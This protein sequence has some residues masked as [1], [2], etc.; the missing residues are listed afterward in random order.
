M[1]DQ[2]PFPEPLSGRYPV[3][4]KLGEGGMGVVYLAHDNNMNCEVVVKM[5]LR[6]ALAEPG[7][8]ER[9]AREIRSMVVLAHPHVVKIQDVGT[10]DEVPFCVMQYLAG[11]SLHER[12]I[13]A[14]PGSLKQWLPAVATA[15]DFVHSQGLLHRDIKPANI[16]FD[17][18]GN[19]YISDFGVAK[20][21]AD[22]AARMGVTQQTGE[23]MIV[24]TVGYLAQELIMGAEKITGAADQYA[25]AATV[26]QVLAGRLPFE[27]NNASAVLV[28]Q[29][30]GKMPPLQQFAPH[31]PKALADVVEK[32]LS[33]NA[34]RRFPT[35]VAFAEAVLRAIPASVPVVAPIRPSPP[36][37]PSTASK[38]P[39]PP[40]PTVHEISTPTKT[41]SPKTVHPVEPK[42]KP[43][44]LPSGG[45]RKEEPR[46]EPER[47]RGRAALLIAAL[48]L[49]AGIAV[50]GVF[51]FRAF[52]ARQKPSAGSTA[53]AR[54]TFKPVGEV[55]VDV[56]GSAPVTVRI[57]RRGHEGPVRLTGSGPLGGVRVSDGTIG[58]GENETT[59]QVEAGNGATGRI[60][61]SVKGYADEAEQTIVVPVRVRPRP[62]MTVQAKGSPPNLRA[63]AVAAKVQLSIVRIACEDRPA[64]FVVD[65]SNVPRG[66]LVNPTRGTI[67]ADKKDFEVRVQAGANSPLGKFSLPITVYLDHH[68][69]ERSVSVELHIV[70]AK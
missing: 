37:P 63:G 40:I 15:L 12:P 56:N 35:C 64:R 61:L 8:A 20:V 21:L 59:L 65:D 25:L 46:E 31:I 42:A 30:A 27:G 38:P 49:I 67:P 43:K 45:W 66:V 1:S 41:Q 3:L 29:A 13:P 60:D 50:G 68:K 5:P 23:G 44:P 2:N 36:K 28:Q 39:K 57:V 9:F 34:A 70:P 26:Y 69:L 17:G 16:L 51:A 52:R 58:A 47:G 32:G 54:F 11:G 7:F 18:H 14:D 4:R 55:V 33:R 48:F 22:K 24:G 53:P 19:A 6:S 62:E 10:H